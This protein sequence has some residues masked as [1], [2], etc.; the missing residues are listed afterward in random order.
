VGESTPDKANI[1]TLA[2]SLGLTDNEFVLRKS[3]LELT[4]QDAQLLR[5]IA[6]PLRRIHP[7]IMDAFYAHLQAFPK[8]RAFIQDP[9]QVQQLRQ[10]QEHYFNELLNGNYDRDYLHKRLKVGIAHQKIGLTTDWYIG[11]YAK[12]LGTLLPELATHAEGNSEKLLNLVMALIKVVFLDINLVLDTYAYVDKL[13]IQSLKEYAENLVCNIPLGLIVVAQDLTILSANQYMDEKFGINHMTMKGT[14]LTQYF[15][16]S[17]LHD[18]AIEVLSSK[19]PQYGVELAFNSNKQLF[20]HC[21][22]SLTPITVATPQDNAS[23]QPAL[24]IVLE[25][26]SERD[27]L[28]ETTHSYDNRVRA[29]VENVAEG[30]ITIDEYGLIESFNP[31]AEALFGYPAGEIIGKNIKQLM[32]SPYREN[33]DQY[34]ARYAATHERRC[35]G[36]GFRE[37]EGLRKD[38]SVFAMDLSI[39]QLA[40]PEKQLYIGI[41]RDITQRKQDEAEM[42]KLS[43]AIEQAAD[44]VMITDKNGL[45]EYVN[46]GFENTTGY[47]RTEVLGRQASILKSGVQDTSFYQNLWQRVEGGKVFQEIF[48]NRKKNGNLYYEEKTITPLR[49]PHGE[50]TH[51]ISTGKDITERMR[52]QKRLQ[53]LAH[54]DVLTTLP[55][56]LLFMDRIAHAIAHAKRNK[57]M[58]ALLFLDL[59]RFKK[60]NDTL[61]HTVGD[62]LLKQLSERLQLGLRQDDTV[63]RLSGDEFA[64]LLPD[65]HH[66]DDILPITSKILQQ[67]NEPFQI[68]NYELFIT[69]SIGIALFPD[70]GT[71]ADT[72]LKNA[73]TAMYAAKAKGR[74]T[75]SFYTPDMNAMASMHL[76]LENELRHA[77][78]R[79][80]FYLVYQPQ[81]SISRPDVILSAEALLRWQH[82]TFGLLNPAEFIPLLEET[83]IIK[84]VGEWIIRSACAQLRDCY[85]LNA[86]LLSLAINIAPQQLTAPDFVD[87]VLTALADFN[88]PA[89]CLELEITEGS[90]MQDEH[91]A[92]AVLSSLHQ[93]GIR[94]AMD[95]FGTG[96]SS[97][98]YLRRLPVN[99]LKIDRSFIH[100]IP[101]ASSDCNLT[102]AIIAMGHS[103]NLQV[104][105]EGVET[106]EQLHYLH[107]LGCDSVQG[108]LLGR[109]M[110]A[111]EFRQHLSIS[112]APG[113]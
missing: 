111:T 56:R 67:F 88:L 72:L 37:V 60:I 24:L 41:V 55:N 73:D 13:S 33:H 112:K 84:Q 74:G 95:D 66:V 81:Y 43:L 15:P 101:H 109:P 78:Q 28:I 102:R 63:A 30:I 2:K 53:F 62:I 93:A 8:T 36:Q 47:S 49:D 46:C 50:I 22:I 83:G 6:E 40:L 17:G 75:F 35:L 16:G 3:Y 29:I 7:K 76:Q 5:E 14:P 64:L 1:E 107:E 100:Q 89:S 54:H 94:I 86:G 38:G 108:F 110:S 25:D 80:Q 51:F 91:R 98:S 82:P 21:E 104:V 65:I 87:T 20:S 32:P 45:I 12:F 52:T 19:N 77:L 58:L 69:T 105:A 39:S 85:D 57:S 68:E 48:V 99:S 70:D 106:P 96:Y 97:L 44:S 9:Q 31:A 71:D 11:A 92:V 61:G 90:L 42:A 18:R 34:L 79:K 4:E 26:T 103:L 23:T 10:K 27:A 113:H 59:D